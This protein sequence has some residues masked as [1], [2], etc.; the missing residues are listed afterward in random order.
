MDE[1]ARRETEVAS[2]LDRTRAHLRQHGPSSSKRQ[3]YD[4]LPG[5]KPLRSAFNACLYEGEAAGYILVTA[6][7]RGHQVSLPPVPLAR[8]S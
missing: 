2:L 6:H 7:G 5:P 8:R 4:T 3:L 1:Q